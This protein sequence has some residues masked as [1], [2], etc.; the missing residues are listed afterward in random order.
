MRR[1]RLRWVILGIGGILGMARAGSGQPFNPT[2]EAV[3]P[4][5]V[6]M[7]E[8]LSEQS[9]DL[10]EEISEDLARQIPNGNDLLRDAQELQRTVNDFRNTLREQRDLYRAR[11]VYSGID[12]TWHRLKGQLDQLAGR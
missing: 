4:E 8:R 3:P 6:Q 11:Q 10:A 12:L 5:L 2:P 7:A 9:Q 1:L